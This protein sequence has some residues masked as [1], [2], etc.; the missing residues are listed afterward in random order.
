[1]KVC[2]YFAHLG[3]G[4]INTPPIKCQNDNFDYNFFIKRKRTFLLL[5]K[6]HFNLSNFQQ[7]SAVEPNLTMKFNKCLL[8]TF[9]EVVV[10]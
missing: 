2:L 5:N 7:I 8:V 3:S 10:F 6:N 9:Y 4:S 1:M